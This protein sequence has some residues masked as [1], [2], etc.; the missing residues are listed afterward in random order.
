MSLNSST[1]AF[2]VGSYGS[3]QCLAFSDLFFF[4]MAIGLLVSLLLRVCVLCLEL[5][6]DSYEMKPIIVMSIITM[7][8]PYISNWMF[9]LQTLG[10]LSLT[11]C[12]KLL[13]NVFES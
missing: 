8:Y 1:I 10:Q 12:H 9:R 11:G 3:S 13:N 7:D 5:L 2:L 6:V 4:H